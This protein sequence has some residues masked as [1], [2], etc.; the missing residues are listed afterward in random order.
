MTRLDRSRFRPDIQGLRAIAVGLVLLYHAGVPGVPGGYVGV[1]VFFVISGF[2]ISSHLLES[3]ERDGRL[4]FGQFYARRARRILPA[5]FVVAGLTAVAVVLFFPPLGVERV[6]RDAF[7]TV[8]YVPNVWFAA[9]NTDYLADHSPSPYQ[10]F[11][12]LGVEEQFYLLWPLA[13]LGLA[14]MCRG[15][16]ALVVTGIALLA[17]VSLAA[18]ILLT[19]TSPPIAFFLLPTRAW[20]LLAGALVGAAVL[21][22]TP[23]V[24]PWI[25]ATGGWLGIGMIAAAAIAFDDAT[26]FPGS[27]AVLPVTGTAAVIYFGT[28][29]S[30]WSPRAMLA[31]RPMQWIGLISYSLYLVHWPLLV[32]P[33]AAIGYERPLPVWATIA[34]GIV[35]AVPLAWALFR[36]VEEPMRAPAR[37]VRRR[38]RVTLL[39]TAA[40]TGVLALLLGGGVAW[41]AGRQLSGGPAVEAAPD[42]PTS[43]PAAATYVPA[44]LTPSLET[45]SEDIPAV[46]PDGCHHD[47]SA[48]SVQDCAY[49][50]PDGSFHVALFGDSH[51]AQWLP[52][53]EA[54]AGTDSDLAIRA[55]TKSSC[56][57]VDV[58]VLDKNVPYLSCDRWRA[59]VMAELTANPPDLVVF[60]SY[61][62]YAIDGVDDPEARLT[63]WADGT[64]RAVAAMRQAGSRVLVIAD[65]PR[66][67]AAPSLCI[68]SHLEDVRPCSALRAEAL[69]AAQTE[70]ER[71]SVEAAGG[72]FVDLTPYLCDQVECPVVVHDLLVYRD[73]NHLTASYVRYL[74]PA[75]ADAVG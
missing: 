5:S 31:V 19:R 27:A 26:P 24:A 15:R 40:V 74:A 41:S 59:A 9:Q 17:A 70:A 12:S 7:A 49:G 57:A 53:L 46:Y 75:L 50:N 64:A 42:H 18:C 32:I 69:D 58:T 23:R 2:L 71:T 61:A 16:R 3:I 33:Q 10:H 54:L 6:L 60:S 8:L 56:P 20:E 62:A 73:V 21:G 13:L 14:L 34:L 55:Y 11:W 36:F 37:L 65:T 63:T 47:V 29:P 4:S 51:S 30:P 48:E 43:P 67:R 22:R 52:A 72:T 28:T 25:A 35:L 45:A 44:N 1:D 38:P 66:F 39:A 68:S